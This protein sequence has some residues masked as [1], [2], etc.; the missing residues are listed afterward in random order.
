MFRNRKVLIWL[1]V[2]PREIE[3]IKSDLYSTKNSFNTY[4][5]LKNINKTLK[6]LR[7][8]GVKPEIWKSQNL[9]FSLLKK[10]SNGEIKLENGKTKDE[11][12]RL[13]NS[14]EVRMSEF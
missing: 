7:G 9:Y 1:T 11:F 10:H 2:N 3:N 14:L 4:N 6:I 5:T 13:G 12:R 8:M